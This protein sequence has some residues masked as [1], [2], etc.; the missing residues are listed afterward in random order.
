MPVALLWV[1]FF[2]FKNQNILIFMLV[3]LLNFEVSGVMSSDALLKPN[4]QKRS[5]NS[6]ILQYITFSSRKFFF[7]REY[8]V[9]YLT[10]FTEFFLS[11]T[12]EFL[13]YFVGNLRTVSA[14]L[15]S[16]S[17]CSYE[18]RIIHCKNSSPPNDSSQ[19]LVFVVVR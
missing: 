10:D 9:T 16:K 11:F 8:L 15:P 1:A 3:I 6:F 4:T 12:Q 14:L 13:P 2:H 5:G 19:K 17:S 18:L 7:K